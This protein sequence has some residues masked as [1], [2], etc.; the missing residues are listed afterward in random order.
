MNPQNFVSRDGTRDA[1]APVE[2]ST[3]PIP[4]REGQR[5]RHILLGHP[6]AI[7]Q[8]MYLLHQLRYVETVQWSPLIQIPNHRLI[9]TTPPGDVMSLLDRHLP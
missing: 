8:T 9:I 4:E 1:I 6:T 7:R 5:L 3:L 2:Q